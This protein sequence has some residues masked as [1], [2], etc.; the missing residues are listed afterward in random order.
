MHPYLAYSV[1]VQQSLGKYKL[2]SFDSSENTHTH[3]H[4]GTHTHTHTHT[5]IAEVILIGGCENQDFVI[6]VNLASLAGTCGQRRHL[7]VPKRT[8]LVGKTSKDPKADSD[9]VGQIIA[10]P[11]FN[12][13]GVHDHSTGSTVS[14]YI[15]SLPGERI[16]AIPLGVG[17]L[18]HHCIMPLLY[19]QRLRNKYYY[20]L[21]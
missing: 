7:D 15:H 6:K 18:V 13:T 9:Q 11:S 3:K 10:M 1:Y 16:H 17:L 5:H 14:A 2:S 12:L 21:I 20:S 19:A 8:N 4:A